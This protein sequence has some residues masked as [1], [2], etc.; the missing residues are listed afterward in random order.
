VRSLN[1]NDY[2]DY[3]EMETK[4]IDDVLQRIH[5]YIDIIR[6]TKLVYIAFDGVAPFAKMK[7]QRK[8]RYHNV[9]FQGSVA[10]SG[11]TQIENALWNNCFITPGTGFMNRLSE[12]LYKEFYQSANNRKTKSGVKIIISASDKPGEGEHKIFQYIRDNSVTFSDY[13]VALYGLDSDLLMLSLL[14]CSHCQNI[15]IFR[16][17]P[18]FDAIKSILKTMPWYAAKQQYDAENQHRKRISIENDLLFMDI[19]AYANE[20]KLRFLY[21]PPTIIGDFVFL[22][23]LF[24]NDFLPRFPSLS[25]KTN[26][27]QV[28]IDI[29]NSILK[30]NGNACLIDPHTKKIQWDTLTALFRGF[31]EIEETLI[32]NQYSVR[33]KTESII[34]KLKTREDILRHF[35]LLDQSIEKYVNP[36]EP[37]WQ[38]RYYKSLFPSHPPNENPFFVEPIPPEQK[39]RDICI[40]YIYGLQWVFEYYS[41]GCSDWKWNY[42]HDYPPLFEDLGALCSKSKGVWL[43]NA[44]M[45]YRTTDNPEQPYENIEQLKYVIP[46]IL[47]KRVLGDA[48]EID[49]ECYNHIPTRPSFLQMYYYH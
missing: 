4:I 5:E 1:T 49:I 35:P 44:I 36:F 7:Q 16:E 45:Q 2:K 42:T 25:L 39:I 19:S 23:F 43:E 22:C 34:P 37:N 20:I 31:S 26:G 38:G 18:E 29:Y 32:F 11:T 40:E 14:H 47:H 12:C 28:L 48:V 21:H 46:P 3:D 24:G 41:I 13:R 27:I 10:T 9:Y 15:Y 8:R 17:L 6:P 33:R 30:K